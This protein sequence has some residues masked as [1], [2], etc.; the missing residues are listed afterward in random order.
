MKILDVPQSGHLGTFVSYR[1]RYGQFRRPYVIPT[2]PQTAAQLRHRRNMGRAAACW[3]T[4][5]DTQFA[6]WI[7]LASQLHSRSQLGKSGSLAGYNLFV[8]INSNLADINE[9]QVTDPP[10]C[11]QFGP[12]PVG[13]LSIT[14]TGGV[15][16]LKLIVPATPT[17][18]TLVLGTK[19]LSRGRSFPGRF[20]F[21]GLLPEPVGDISDIT[22]LYKAQYGVPPVNT[23]VFIRTVQQV[24]GWKNIPKQTTAVV[25]TA[26]P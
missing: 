24:N 6:A 14:N 20:V 9:P 5:T 3:R 19:P 15:I 17:R 4:L 8:R 1:T 12:N 21:L 2:D 18:H 11:P 25:P 23:R 26:Q 10:D 16:A 7:A 22:E 13:D